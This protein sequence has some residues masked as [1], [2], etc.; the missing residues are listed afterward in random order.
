MRSENGSTVGGVG[1][2]G[3]ARADAV[4]HVVSTESVPRVGLL[5]GVGWATAVAAA[6]ASAEPVPTSLGTAKTEAITL[7]RCW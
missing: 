6:G 5:D 1:K 2:P 4:G 3:E 7:T